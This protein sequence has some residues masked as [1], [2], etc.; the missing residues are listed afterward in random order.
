MSHTERQKT[1]GYAHTNVH[2]T[3]CKRA[4]YSTETGKN[5]S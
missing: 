5:S 2:M 1:V 3:V 4:N